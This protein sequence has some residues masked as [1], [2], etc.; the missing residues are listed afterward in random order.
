MS[1]ATAA[2]PA[3]DEQIAVTATPRYNSRGA[4]W[5]VAKVGPFPTREAALAAAEQMLAARP[6]ASEEGQ[7]AAA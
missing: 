4:V 7:Q 1:Q 6:A 2:T 5:A 3:A